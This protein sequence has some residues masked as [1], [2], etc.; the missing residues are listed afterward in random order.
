[1]QDNAKKLPVEKIET[2]R[3]SLLKLLGVGS[4]GTA[5]VAMGAESATAE[6]ATPADANGYRESEHVK[7][8]YDRARF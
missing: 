5:A 6:V 3:R 2:D 4:V 7:T 8:Y 1:M